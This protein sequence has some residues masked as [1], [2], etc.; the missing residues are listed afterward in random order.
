MPIVVRTRLAASFLAIAAAAPASAQFVGFL[1][2]IVTAQSNFNGDVID[3]TTGDITGDGVPDIVYLIQ[4]GRVAF[5]RG[6]ASGQIQSPSTTIVVA[7][8]DGRGIDLFDYDNDWDLDV[9]RA[10]SLDGGSLRIYENLGNGTF[11]FDFAIIGL[12]PMNGTKNVQMGDFD[13]DGDKDAYVMTDAGV[14]IVINT[15]STFSLTPVVSTFLNFA[16]SL[17]SVADFNGDGRD[18][19]AAFSSSN[20]QVYLL[21]AGPGGLTDI[22]RVTFP[23]IAND[24]KL[25]NIDPEI[26][27]DADLVLAGGTTTTGVIRVFRNNGSG[28]FSLAF[29]LP[30]PNPEEF[31]FADMSADGFVDIV[32]NAREETF[33]STFNERLIIYTNNGNG[34]FNRNP[35]QWFFASPFVQEIE[36]ADV[37]S[38]S[39]IDVIGMDGVLFSG[40]GVQTLSLRI[41][42]TPFLAPSDFDLIAPVDNISGLPLP[43]DIALWGGRVRPIAEWGAA[44]GFDVSYQMV[45]STSPSL[46]N[47]VATVPAGADLIADLSSV[48]L[49]PGET[50]FWDVIASNTAGQTMSA[51]GPFSFTTASAMSDCPADQ[52]FDGMLAPNDFASWIANFNAGCP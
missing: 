5:F 50:Y 22:G 19:A 12:G 18:D 17:F 34:F 38:A 29:S 7:D 52:N 4:N 24:I 31:E 47:P 43:T 28:T 36:L 25:F 15:G 39:G 46:S 26:D 16:G 33:S 44:P 32:V 49:E 2:D 42:A 51:N 40:S 27:A 23:E 48:V 3:M 41:N 21:R 1:P 14:S 8:N 45:I 35:A 11:S 30:E 20:N 10:G 6:A 37:V 9:M 13:G